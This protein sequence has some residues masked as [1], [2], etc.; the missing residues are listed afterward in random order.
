MELTPA[1]PHSAEQRRDGLSPG[2]GETAPGHDSQACQNSGAALLCQG[3]K[4][5]YA[6]AGAGDRA[7]D[8]C[9]GALERSGPHPRGR[10]SLE[11]GGPRPRERLPLEWGEPRSRGVRCVVLAGRGGHQGRGRAVYASRCAS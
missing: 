5:P 10:G 2:V 1:S 11:R 8:A 3:I 4:C 7:G 9:V 6:R